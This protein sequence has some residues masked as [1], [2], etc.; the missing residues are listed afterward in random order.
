MTQMEQ[1][2]EIM[3]QNLE[4]RL[5]QLQKEK[6]ELEI[7]MEQEQEFMVNRLNRQLTEMKKHN[8]S[9]NSLSSDTA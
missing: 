4:K 1:E 7:A 8:S 6:L 2:E 5:T 9:N 3:A